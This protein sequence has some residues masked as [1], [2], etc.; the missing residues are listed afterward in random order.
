MVYYSQLEAILLSGV[1]GIPCAEVVAV[2]VVSG[3]RWSKVVVKVQVKSEKR[4]WGSKRTAG[5]KMGP[6]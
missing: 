5:S 6:R 3:M 1:R 2:V 4:G